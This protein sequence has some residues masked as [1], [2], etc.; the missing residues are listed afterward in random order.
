LKLEVPTTYVPTLR[1]KSNK[2]RAPPPRP[3]VDVLL[4][5]VEPEIVN[6]PTDGKRPNGSPAEYC[7]APPLV[8]VELLLKVHPLMVTVPPKF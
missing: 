1:L 6:V 7:T 8:S 3:A 4:E 5:N 2:S